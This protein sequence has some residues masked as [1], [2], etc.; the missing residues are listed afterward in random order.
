MKIYY[1]S[2]SGEILNLME[3]PY[4]IREAEFL[5]HEWSYT[6]KENTGNKSGGKIT[7][8]RKK[9]AKTKMII[10]FFAMSKQEYTN[11]V[12]YFL[13]VTEKDFLSETPGRIYVDDCYYTCY[14]YGSEKK[15]WERM[16]TYLQNELKI[17]SPYP[18]WCREVTKSFLKNDE[19]APHENTGE[20]LYYP[21]GYPYRYSIP[22]N[23]AYL[24]NDHYAACDF[25]MTVY[26]PCTNP[27][28][29]INGHVYE[30]LTTLYTGDYLV[31][32]S[33]DNTV[34]QYKNDGTSENK[35]NFRNKDSGLF[36]KIPNGRCSILWNTE[37]FGFDLTLFQERSEPK[38]I[39]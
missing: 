19:S 3:W 8:I 1:K 25:K 21:F 17:V 4:K 22:R 18:F 2:N 15:E 37:A 7:A 12:D 20:F 38:W 26:G 36:E 23:L 35:F 29:M 24:Q 39:L 5:N 31:I 28:I 11:A 16:T 32:D 13:Q 6:G 30:V 9:I 14:I 27:A 34:I 33:R 10:D